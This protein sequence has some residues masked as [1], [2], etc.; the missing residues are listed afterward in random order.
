MDPNKFKKE[1][2]KELKLLG[3]GSFGDVYLAEYHGQKY[4]LK[5]IPKDKINHNKYEED[6]IYMKNALLKEIDILKTMSQFENSVKF[7][8]D[9]EDEENYIFILEVCDT[10]LDGLLRK[11]KKFSSSEILYIMEG[12]NKPLKYMANNNLIH[13]DI[14]PDN[15]MIKYIDNSKTKYIPKLTDFG[16][17]RYLEEGIA[18]TFV[19][20]KFY[21]A[22]EIQFDSS[23]TN[24]VDLFSIGVMMYE[25]YFNNYPFEID[26]KGGGN[27]KILYK[28]KKLKDCEDKLLDDLLNK[29]LILDPKKRITWKDYF[30]HPF[31]NSNKEVEEL[32]KKLNNMKLY[33]E[34]EHKIINVYDYIL[35][36]IIYQNN[37][38]R[39]KLKEIDLQQFISIDE[40]LLNHKNDSF[41]ILGI[42]GK[43]LEQ[44][45]ISVLIQKVDLPADYEMREYHKNIFLFI[46]NSYILK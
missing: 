39:E 8:L 5:K 46:C 11:K 42:I 19:G 24:K 31:F 43:Y 26:R 22:P 6:N 41:F 10:N 23:Y 7:Y 20:T 17:S 35:E 37:I 14:K 1:D 32:N 2:L 33:D 9:F 27:Y 34:K 29:L 40:C 25:L 4:A 44:I 18:S 3:Q 15:I 28:D 38:E 16:V 13:R 45:G 30:N 21:K 36:K 12:L